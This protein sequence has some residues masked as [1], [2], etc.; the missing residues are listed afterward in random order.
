MY[1][2]IGGHDNTQ[3]RLGGSWGEKGLEPR[4]YKPAL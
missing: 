4:Q 2:S 1:V 3:N